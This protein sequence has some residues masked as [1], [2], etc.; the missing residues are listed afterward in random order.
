[1][2]A[3]I[4]AVSAI[5]AAGHRR[6]PCAAALDC[7]LRALSCAR[8]EAGPRG[9]LSLCTF[10]SQR[11][12]VFRMR[13][14]LYFRARSGFREPGLRTSRGIRAGGRP[15]GR[16]VRAPRRAPDAVSRSRPQ[17]RTAHN[18]K[19][20]PQRVRNV[21]ARGAT[22]F[23]PRPR[24]PRS[25]MDGRT[26]DAALS[27]QPYAHAPLSTARP[28]TRSLCATLQRPHAR[29]PPPACSPHTI[30]AHHSVV[31]PSPG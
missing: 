23:H 26:R 25:E 28:S 24:E 17:A 14:R 10:S 8:A 11:R 5:F 21:I 13:R 2:G 6:L 16:G 29:G 1:M 22:L 12:R 3:R 19:R 18:H 15:A 9:R 20:R 7:P 31:Q 4:D 30:R 27:P